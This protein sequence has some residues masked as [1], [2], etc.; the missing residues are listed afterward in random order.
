MSRDES[1]A[2]AL[3]AQHSRR[4]S[5]GGVL[6]SSFALLCCAGAA[7]VLGL[8]SAIGLGFLINDAVLIPFLVFALGVTA[9][10]LW[11]GRRCHGRGSP[12]LFGLGGAGLA[13]GG[14]FL[15]VPLAFAGFAAVILASAWNLR[16]L[17]TCTIPS[18]SSA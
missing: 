9:W 7:P 8:L 5:L 11:H 15:W 1:P 6:G 17:R 12:L 3:S 2:P 16:L 13:V 10:G 14:L 4:A 18:S